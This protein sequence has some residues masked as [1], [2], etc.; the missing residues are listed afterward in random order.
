MR[1]LHSIR[2]TLA[3]L[4]LAAPLAASAQQPAPAATLQE[5]GAANFTIFVRGTAIGT[6]QIALTRSPLLPTHL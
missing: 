4:A 1:S 6:E 3:A 5:T 2:A